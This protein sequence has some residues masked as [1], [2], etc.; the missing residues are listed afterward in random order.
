M[1]NDTTNQLFG[2]NGEGLRAFGEFTFKTE[3]SEPQVTFK[4][5][6]EFGNVMEKHTLL[7]DILIQ[8]KTRKKID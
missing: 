5:I 4:L 7:Y 1:A 6:D 8:K 2:Y 3:E